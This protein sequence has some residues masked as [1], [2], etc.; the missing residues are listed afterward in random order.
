MW[1]EL[2]PVVIEERCFCFPERHMD[3]AQSCCLCFCFRERKTR[4]QSTI[5]LHVQKGVSVFGKDTWTE[6]SPVVCADRCFCFRERHVDRAYAR[7][8]LVVRQRGC[9]C[10]GFRSSFYILIC[11][12]NRQKVFLTWC[13]APETLP[14]KTNKVNTHTQNNTHTH[15]HT[16]PGVVFAG[17]TRKIPCNKHGPRAE[18]FPCDKKA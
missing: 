1:T 4:G 9:L 17:I 8:H 18:E 11:S 6:L 2:N 15:T 5:L 14:A 10:H 13:N 7:V 12:G 16:H 3:R